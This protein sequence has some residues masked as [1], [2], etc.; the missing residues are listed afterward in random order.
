MA[1]RVCLTP[2]VG[3]GPEIAG[4]ASEPTPIRWSL[5]AG[6][7]RRLRAAARRETP[8][9]ATSKPTESMRRSDNRHRPDWIG[10][11]RAR[12]S[13][14]PQLQVPKLRA[15]TWANAARARQGGRGRTIWQFG[16]RART[17]QFASHCV[18]SLE[19]S[20]SFAITSPCGR[21][22]PETGIPKP[23]RAWNR[24][25]RQGGR[26]GVKG[27]PGRQQTAT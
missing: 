22:I 20:A 17:A 5:P 4:A 11:D 18:F 6:S 24:V 16:L 13:A 27:S 19:T 21:L 26:P 25:T 2:R 10:P 7:D 3:R 1:I 14:R 15:P 8:E 12:S 9:A 23:S